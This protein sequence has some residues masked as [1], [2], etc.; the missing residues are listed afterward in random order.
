MQALAWCFALA[1]AANEGQRTDDPA[2]AHRCLVVPPVAADLGCF[3]IS[4]DVR[5][6]LEWLIEEPDLLRALLVVLRGDRVLERQAS[7]FC[8]V[9]KPLIHCPFHAWN[10]PVPGWP[11]VPDDALRRWVEATQHS[12]ALG[13]I[14]VTRL[15][16][17]I[18]RGRV[19]IGEQIARS[20]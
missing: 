16:T 9:R 19:T 18:A 7:V 2:F 10:E 4:G 13:T 11:S 8:G 6:D 20:R 5:L 12:E 1:R 14:E 15:R 3:R 17:A